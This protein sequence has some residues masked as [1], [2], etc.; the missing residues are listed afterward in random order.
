MRYKNIVI[1]GGSLISAVCVLAG[2][3][4]YFNQ[5][6]CPVGTFLCENSTICMPQRNWCNGY[7]DCPG[8]DDEA[9]ISCFD[10]HGFW[11]WFFKPRNTKQPENCGLVEQCLKDCS[12]TN[13]IVSCSGYEEIPQTFSPNVS[14]ITFT[15]SAFNV[16]SKHALARY[17][18]IRSLFFEDNGIER[19][20]EG[21]FINQASLYWLVLSD[22]KL[23][24]IRK[25]QMTGLSSLE[26]LMLD[27][28]SLSWADFADF[29]NSTSLELIDLSSNLLTTDQ[30]KFPYLPGL[31]DLMLNN[32]KLEKLTD[33][34]FAKLPTLRSLSLEANFI[35]FIDP[36]AL[37]SLIMLTELNLA[38]NN[39]VDV[40]QH[41]F[42]PVPNMTKLMI[43]YNP[44]EN[45]P[46][47]VFE[48]LKNLESLG[49]E[50]IDMDNMENNVF[51]LFTKLDFVYFK[52]FY[53]CTTYAPKVKKCRPAS[54]GVSSLSHL[55]GKPLLRAAV[56]SISAVT[57]L[58]NALVLWG[59]FTAKDENRVLSIIIRNLAVSDMLMGFYLFIIGLEDVRFRD[60]YNQEASSW[61]SSWSCTIVGI[62]AM[63]SSE[64]SVMIL[65]FMSVERFMLIA[66]PLKRHRSLT[67]QAAFSS[68]IA[69][70][71]FGIILALIPAIHWRSSTRYYGVNGMCFPLHIDDPFLIGWE[72][73]AFI[74]LGLNLFG[75]VTIGYVYSGMFASIWRTRHNTPLSV[76]DSEFAFRFF[77]IVLTDA[78]CWAPI[79]GLKILAF[80]KYPVPPDLHAWVVVFILPVNSAINPLL[81]T[82]TTPKFRERLNEGWLRKMRNYATRKPSTQHS[83]SSSSLATKNIARH[84]LNTFP[85]DETLPIAYNIDAHLI[86]LRQHPL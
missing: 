38:D 2:L 12:C 14:T 67:P 83:Q 16:I 29:E 63:T 35:K 30:L 43:G 79:I 19:I 81:Y 64:V 4:Y 1:V 60:N 44:I 80:L 56:W 36:N 51:D 26:T 54:D 40:P 22:N 84:Q 86:E 31:K 72:Y 15:E 61:M 70:W 76:G 25:G 49:V 75:L 9:K 73:S 11:D 33:L 10:F 50:E 53:Y 55:L 65:S 24:E 8:G 37:K 58:G 21:S 46:M 20:E 13:C 48:P 17:T 41:F 52:K 85:I 18:Q 39:I 32:N 69:I 82:F 74:F 7:P 71:I 34:T 42:R 77:L 27:N 59:R 68:M 57:C 66:A 62:L 23:R 6:E 78:A 28:N 3:M 47:S 5:D 45:L